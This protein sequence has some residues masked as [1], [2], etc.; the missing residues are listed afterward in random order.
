MVNS[1]I[2][3]CVQIIGP[4]LMQA[5]SLQLLTISTTSVRFER[6][7]IRFRRWFNCFATLVCRFGDKLPTV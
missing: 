4:L 7:C 2:D 6:L 1:Y 3:A 5:A